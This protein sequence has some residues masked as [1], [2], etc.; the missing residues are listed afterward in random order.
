M[1]ESKRQHC[2]CTTRIKDAPP[3][4]RTLGRQTAEKSIAAQLWK[5]KEIKI[6]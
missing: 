1:P 2:N 6:R 3:P 5:R 4:H